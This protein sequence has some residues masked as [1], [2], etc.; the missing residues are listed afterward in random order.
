IFSRKLHNGQ[1]QIRDW[2]LYSSSKNAL[3][4]FHCVLFSKRKS[5][6]GNLQYGL[7][8]WAKCYDKVQKHEKSPLHCESVRIW[9]LR[10]EGAKNNSINKVLKEEM[11]SKISYWTQVLRRVVSTITFLA[12]RGLSFRGNN[13]EFGSVHNGNYMGCLELIA[14]FDPFLCEHIA[15]YGNKGRGNVSYLS[16]IICDEFIQLMNN[17]VADKIVYEINE[18]KYFSIIVD[19]T[20]DISK[21]DQLT[22][23]IRYIT[24]TGESKERFLA[25]LPSV[26]HKG[27]Q[28]EYALIKKFNELGIELK[29]CRGQ[30]Y[31]N[32]SN[33]SGVY[34]G[35]QARIK[36]YA[37]NAVF[38]PCA[39]HSLNLIGSNAAESSKEGTQFFYTIQ[40]VYTFLSS[41]TYRWELL[42]NI[43]DKSP[44]KSTSVPKNLCITRWSSRHEACKGI[45]S[46]YKEILEVLKILSEDIT[47][48]PS[49]RNEAN[50]IRKKLEKL[51]F[52]FMLNVWTPILQRFDATNKTLQSKDINLSIV[53]SLYE[54][55]ELYVQDYR[56]LFDNI[57]N[58]SKE[59]CGKLTFSWEKSRVIKKKRH[60]D[61]SNS[62]DTIHHGEDKM[63]NDTFYVIIDTLSSNL[64]ERKKAYINVHSNFGF[65]SNLTNLDSLT[66]RRKALHIVNIYNQ[67]IDT[68]FIEEIV[69]FKKIAISFSKED[70]TING[71]F[72][73]LSNS[74]LALTFP[75]V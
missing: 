68:S 50:S 29:N 65:L 35:L 11:Y 66:L 46:G 5:L 30:S 42:K 51:E 10:T 49:T 69:Q 74:P 33:M 8:N 18:S 37:S 34:K 40:M 57:L 39:A 55:L 47:Q 45:L 16:S 13:S 54:S 48:T 6:L 32:A 41:S 67:D 53:V 52:V 9:Y 61:D 27:E 19:S 73:K 43:I 71:L 15:K 44:S 28:M 75:N 14:Q 58:K 20:P 60:F 22:V 21:T 23:V 2:L 72:T 24:A 59:L 1:T 31:D 36:K 26:G 56:K 17:S 25:F 4:C 3:F 7:K 62:V 70:L 63:K 12:E 64:C 38:V